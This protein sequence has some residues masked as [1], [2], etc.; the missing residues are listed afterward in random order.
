MK[1]LLVEEATLAQASLAPDLRAF[2][3]AVDVV[4]DDR[5]AIGM[6]SEHDYDVVV[7][8]LIWSKQSNL[9]VLHEIRE[10]DRNV[11]ILILST[12]DQIHDQVTALI[13]GA[14]DYLSRPFAFDELLMRIDELG[15]SRRS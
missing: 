6:A 14:N 15:N 13:Q 2:G 7:L 12:R 11:K 3:Y 5:H 1:L 9:L 8:D 4:A 10:S